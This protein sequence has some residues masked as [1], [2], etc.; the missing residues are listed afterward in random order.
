MDNYEV[1]NLTNYQ[2]PDVFDSLIKYITIKENIKNTFISIVLCENDY[3]KDINKKYRNINK[4]TDVLSFAIESD[5]L[6]VS[7]IGEIYINVDKMKE[8]A[9]A[10]NHSETREISF[11]LTHGMLHLLG[12]NHEK[13]KEEKIMIEKQE[14]I[15]NE[16]KET[17][18]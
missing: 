12:Y 10:L 13:E 3:I 16:F 9:L 8:Q 15:L 17:K 11:L 4:P 7:L 18:I 1:V 6:D 5:N 2:I 14:R